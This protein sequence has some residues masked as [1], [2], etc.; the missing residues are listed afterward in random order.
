[1]LVCMSERSFPRATAAELVEGA[2]VAGVMLSGVGLSGEQVGGG[3]ADL[4]GGV[5]LSGEQVGGGLAVAVH[6]RTAGQAAESG[7]EGAG[8]AGWLSLFTLF[9]RRLQRD[10]ERRRFVWRAGGWR[11][12]CLGSDGRDAAPCWECFFV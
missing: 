6:V 11:A 5:G 10:V 7:G 3:L 9:L 8:V 12:L 4:S 1:M 2:G